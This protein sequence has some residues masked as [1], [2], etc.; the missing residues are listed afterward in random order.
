[1]KVRDGP[2]TCIARTSYPAA[3]D[4]WN[5]SGPD[6]KKAHWSPTSLNGT[7]GA[8][9]T[10]SSGGTTSQLRQRLYPQ[11]IHKLWIRPASIHQPARV[12]AL[13][14]ARVH[15]YPAVLDGVTHH[16]YW[17]GHEW[18]G[19]DESLPMTSAGFVQ[20]QQQQYQ[21]QPGMRSQM[22]QFGY[23]ML[24]WDCRVGCW[25]ESG[26]RASQGCSDRCVR[27]SSVQGTHVQ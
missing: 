11:L 2:E 25:V 9:S 14:F 6:A 4:L 1:M 7:T 19:A 16:Q 23:G 21:Q 20:Q 22:G 27:V 10:N 12:S 8:L 18:A 17:G 24:G 5:Q 3:R 13:Q 15:A 26:T